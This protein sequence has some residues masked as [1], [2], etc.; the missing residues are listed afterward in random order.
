M[1][2]SLCLLAILVI[3]LSATTATAGQRSVYFN[4]GLAWADAQYE[5]ETEAFLD[6]IEDLPGVDRMSVGVDLTLYFAVSPSTLIGATIN[7][8]G[9]R[10]DDGDDDI[11]VNQYIYGGSVRHYM[12]GMIGRGLYVRGDIGMAKIRIDMSS[13]DDMTSDAG[14]GFLLGA[15]YSFPAFGDHSFSVNADYTSKS[16]EDENYGGFTVGMGFMF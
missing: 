1:K 7:G 11:Q 2:R 5:D 8:I 15:G 13:G 9:D 12:S 16:V 14:F 6:M 10:F 3:A 4:L